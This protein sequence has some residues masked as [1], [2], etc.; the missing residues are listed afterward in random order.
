[1]RFFQSRGDSDLFRLPAI[2]DRKVAWG[3][4]QTLGDVMGST[5]V[6]DSL[7]GVP[8]TTRESSLSWRPTPPSPPGETMGE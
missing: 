5:T 8:P 2:T 1:M 6:E 7:N 4:R 3:K